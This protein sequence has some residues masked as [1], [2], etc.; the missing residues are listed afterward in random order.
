MT[1]A[2]IALGSNLSEPQAQVK[3]AVVAL[4]KHPLISVQ[5]CSPWYRST[6]IGPGEQEDYVNGVIE[7]KAHTDDAEA[8]LDILQHIEHTQGRVRTIKWGPRTLDLD[9]LTYGDHIIE[10]ERLTVPHPRICERNFVL[11]PLRDL[12]PTLQVDGKPVSEHAAAISAEGIWRLDGAA[13]E[14]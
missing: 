13:L 10:T 3:S 6:A 8:L 14:R 2:F 4:T 9:L 7:V 12:A 1:L 11:F 5:R